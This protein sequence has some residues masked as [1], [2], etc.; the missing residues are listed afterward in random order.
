MDILITQS[1]ATASVL[2][3]PRLSLIT[4]GLLPS[5]VIPPADVTVIRRQCRHFDEVAIAEDLG[6]SKLLTD[7][8]AACN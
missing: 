7:P 3:E 6:E 4:V 8:P 1:S 2:V 5:H